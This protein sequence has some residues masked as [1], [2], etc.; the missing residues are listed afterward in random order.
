MPKALVES[1]FRDL[2]R[3]FTPQRLKHVQEEMARLK[4]LEEAIKPLSHIAL[5]LEI[6]AAG[7]ANLGEQIINFL[8]Y[9]TENTVE[10]ALE[11]SAAAVTVH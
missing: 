6:L 10:R 9:F 5:D 11:L 1:C 3:E 4:Y 8:V 2:E 7:D